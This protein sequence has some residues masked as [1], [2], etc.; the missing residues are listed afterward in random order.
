MGGWEGQVS[1]AD[2]DGLRGTEGVPV[3]RVPL[4]HQRAIQRVAARGSPRG[5]REQR[6]EIVA[7]REQEP[8]TLL[9]ED[10]GP[11]RGGHVP[12]QQGAPGRVELGACPLDLL[13]GEVVVEGAASGC[14][15]LAHQR[16]RF[17]GRLVR[18][19]GRIASAVR[20]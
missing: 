5:R 10:G 12:W 8:A 6:G 19:C 3:A 15:L 9:R 18:H 17:L 14:A 7:G 4:E 16:F 20:V 1:G 13:V 11:A 2:R